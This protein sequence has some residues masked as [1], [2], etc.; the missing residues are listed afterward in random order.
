MQIKPRFLPTQAHRLRADLIAQAGDYLLIDERGEMQTM[1]EGTFLALYDTGVSMTR[2]SIVKA[3]KGEMTHMERVVCAFAD[4]EGH[5]IT[6]VSTKKLGQIAG[7]P[8][9]SASSR[10]SDARQKGW[11]VGTS[12]NELGQILWS[13]TPAGVEE[14]RRLRGRTV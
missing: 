1:D 10:L 9:N 4:A 3:K 6:D 8:H 14:V 7:I 12:T 2:R 13:L 5:F 11:V